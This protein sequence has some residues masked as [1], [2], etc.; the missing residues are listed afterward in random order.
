MDYFEVKVRD[1]NYLVNPMIEADNLLFTTEVNGYEV[2][3]ATT[4]DGLQ[5]I[6]PPEVD[7]ELLAEIASE[8]DSYMM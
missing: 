3:F 7:Q 5:A 2:L 1:V 6:D 4:S 8:I